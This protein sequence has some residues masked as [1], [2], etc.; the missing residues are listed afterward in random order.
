MAS[1]EREPITASGGAPPL[2]GEGGTNECTDQ[3][4]EGPN[5]LWTLNQN[6]GG[7]MAPVATAVAPP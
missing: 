6:F 1:A 5:A 4:L 2:V 7:A 3:L